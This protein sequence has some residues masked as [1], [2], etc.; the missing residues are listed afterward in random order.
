MTVSGPSVVKN[1]G[2]CIK[3]T[4]TG[5]NQ[6]TSVAIEGTLGNTLSANAP[7]DDYIIE[8]IG[9]VENDD[10]DGTIQLEFAQNTSNPTALTIKRGSFVKGQQIG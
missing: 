7:A 10:T 8:V 9:A 1:A 3:V 5:I 2:F 6:S 4:P